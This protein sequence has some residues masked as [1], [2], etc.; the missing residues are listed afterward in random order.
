MKVK[1]Q[2]Y[3]NEIKRLD[4]S[5]ERIL[6]TKENEI[7]NLQKVYE[8]KTNQTRLTGEERVIEVKHQGERK[9]LQALKS[10]EEKLTEYK[11]GLSKTIGQLE[12]EKQELTF[13]YINQ[14]DSMRGSHSENIKDKFNTLEEET[15]NINLKTNDRVKKIVGD[16][17]MAIENAGYDNRVRLDH[18]LREGESKIR[19]EKKNQAASLKAEELNHF[20]DTSNMKLTHDRELSRQMLEN[21]SELSSKGIAHRKEMEVKDANYS[22]SIKN[23]HESFKKKYSALSQDHQKV[24][25]KIQS[26]FSNEIESMVETHAQ[27]KRHIASKQ[28]D[29]FYK[30]K[31]IEPKIQTTE[32]EYLVSL[33]IP[34]HEKDGVRL[35]ANDRTLRLHMTRNFSDKFEASDGTLNKS[36]RSEIFTK[37][38]NVDE[39]VDSKNIS[40]TYKDGTMYIRVPKK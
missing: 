9:A 10:N 15:K 11:N 19:I 38:F 35:S 21:T 28:D 12:R 36:K 2:N 7:Q 14:M 3:Q 16:S 37:E 17:N 29:S 27:K 4:S 31:T 24:L 5:R 40:Q 30:V 6:K 18:E 32:K 39:I 1:D 23:K 13:N 34:E 22:R 8:A 20:Q 25:T 33:A 26:Q